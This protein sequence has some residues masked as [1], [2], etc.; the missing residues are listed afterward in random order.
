MLFFLLCHAVQ[1]RMLRKKPEFAAIGR[2]LMTA[3][4]GFLA[5]I[6]LLTFGLAWYS[7]EFGQPDPWLTSI[8][9]FGTNL[10]A[11]VLFYF[12]AP[13]LF[14]G[15]PENAAI[16]RQ[17]LLAMLLFIMLIAAFAAAMI[18]GAEIRSDRVILSAMGWLFVILGNLMPKLKTN[19]WAGIRVK[20]TMEDP[21][22]W[23]KTHRFS[24]RLW[25][26][27]GLA[28]AVAPFLLSTRDAGTILLPGLVI[29]VPVPILYAWCLARRKRRFTGT[30][31]DG[32]DNS[33]SA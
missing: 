29:L 3:I 7:S 6:M 4:M 9:F 33:R 14:P 17:I 16:T 31:R 26:A 21:E 23:Y 13:R 2:R 18:A 25:I 12:Y 19:P 5:L 30:P 1:L 20:W 28:L 22:I 10:S 15:Q 32:Q 24:G 11:L 27:G 8:L